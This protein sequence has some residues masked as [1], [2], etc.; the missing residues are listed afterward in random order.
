MSLKQN[1]PNAVASLVLGILSIVTG[2]FF[3]GLVLGIIGMVLASNGM[4]SYLLDPSAYKNDG[5][6]RAG[7]IL[8]IIGIV[9][10][11]VHIVFAIISAIALGGSLFFFDSIFHI[12]D[13]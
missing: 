4:K 1:A 8:S 7:K 5:M 13:F 11:S 2:C 10:S 3:V 6:L 12:L 9:L